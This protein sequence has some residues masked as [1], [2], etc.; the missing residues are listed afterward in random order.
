MNS[1]F[2]PAIVAVALGLLAVGV[3]G[4][5]LACTSADLSAV[6]R[7]E[8]LEQLREATFSRVEVR[9]R[10]VRQV[11]DRRRT[12]A[13]ALERFQELDREWPDFSGQAS[14]ARAGRTEDE[15]AYQHILVIVEESLRERPEKAAAVLRRLE[16][17]YR[18]LHADRQTPSTGATERTEQSR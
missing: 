18:Q 17:E 11:I 5:R 2:R 3:L 4:L 1:Q 9:Q 7:N 15:W 8:E 13:E 14:E 10:V 6:H 12:L 16:K